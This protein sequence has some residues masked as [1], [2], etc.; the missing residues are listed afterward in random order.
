MIQAQFNNPRSATQ[1]ELKELLSYELRQDCET[2][3]PD[4]VEARVE[5]AINEALIAVWEIENPTCKQMVVY[6]SWKGITGWYQW[7]DV[8]HLELVKSHRSR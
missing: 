3:F 2:S 8:G 4:N 6:W 5:N 1:D 7:S